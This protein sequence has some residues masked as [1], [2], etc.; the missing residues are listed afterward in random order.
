MNW[1]KCW[2][3]IMISLT[4][5]WLR[6]YDFMKFPTQLFEDLFFVDTRGLKNISWFPWNLKQKT[7]KNA[8][9]S[10]AKPGPEGWLKTTVSLGFPLLQKFH[11]PIAALRASAPSKM[12]EG[13]GVLSVFKK[14]HPQSKPKLKCDIYLFQ[15]FVWEARQ[16]HSIFHDVLWSFIVQKSVQSLHIENKTKAG[17]WRSII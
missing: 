9:N 12:A 4:K 3:L 1:P 7:P 10:K 14:L 13:E 2:E 5:G 11:H 16:E 6:N 17:T 8:R 15:L